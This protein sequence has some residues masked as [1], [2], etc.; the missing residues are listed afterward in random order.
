[1]K[2]P[3]KHAQLALQYWK[4]AAEDSEAHKNW[5]FRSPENNDGQW[6]S[7]TMDPRFRPEFEYRRKPRTIRIGDRDVPEPLRELPKDGVV[8][9]L[10]LSG[11]KI[12]E[13]IPVDEIVYLKIPLNRGL[14]FAT[15]EEAKAAAEAILELLKPEP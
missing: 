5:E 9:M 8:W 15:E 13:A 1:M 4:E 6:T 7:I 12:I 14:L 3:H 10:T 2:T 11:L